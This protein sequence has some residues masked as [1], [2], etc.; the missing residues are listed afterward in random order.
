MGEPAQE[1]FAAGP[2]AAIVARVDPECG[3]VGEVGAEPDFAVV[4]G[5]NVFE[6]AE[7]DALR[8]ARSLVA[9]ACDEVVDP[10]CID[11][12]DAGVVC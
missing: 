2:D 10:G 4:G 6:A 1:P 8:E 12:P 7:A 3:V 9:L 5:D 11:Q